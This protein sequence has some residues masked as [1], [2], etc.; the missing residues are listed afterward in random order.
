MLSVYDLGVNAF[1]DQ[2]DDDAGCEVQDR[3]SVACFSQR[4]IREQRGT[5]SLFSPND[6]VVSSGA[7]SDIP[8]A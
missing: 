3:D 6:P 7:C 1:T 8:L 2:L 4:H 5:A